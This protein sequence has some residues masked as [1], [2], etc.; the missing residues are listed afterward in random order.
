M[1]EPLAG[2][3]SG[4]LLDVEGTLLLHD[5]AVPGAAEALADLRRR[6]LPH[7]LL[8][9]TSRRSRRATAAAL[10]AAGLPGSPGLVLTPAVLARRLILASGRAE[11]FLLVP[12]EARE[13]L[14]GVREEE[15]APAWVVVADVGSGF[16]HE[17]LSAAFR[18][19]RRG[20]RLLALHRNPCWRPADGVDWV[21]DAGAYVAALEYASGLAAEVVG[22]PSPAF[23]R[24]ALAEIGLPPE[25]VLVVGDDPRTDVAGAAAV[26]CRTLLVRTGP[27]AGGLPAAGPGADRVA[28]SV[29]ELPRLLDSWPGPEQRGPGGAC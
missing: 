16:T 19:L 1:K 22:K 10:A 26:G 3:V 2:P 4:V 8:T 24:L 17:R 6:S 13:D 14:E 20:A 7:R 21:L 18:C 12:P 25:Q 28:G 23:F 15:E 29:A 11:A 27:S 5:R 9:N